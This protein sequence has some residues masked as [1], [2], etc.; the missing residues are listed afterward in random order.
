MRLSKKQHRYRAD[1]DWDLLY[2]DAYWRNLANTIEPPVCGSDAAL[3]QIT[4]TTCI[5]AVV[6][7]PIGICDS[8]VAII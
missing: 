5:N 2:R 6:V 8:P 7:V 3:S 1:A 4:L